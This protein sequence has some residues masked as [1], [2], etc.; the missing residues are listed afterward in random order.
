MTNAL[1]MVLVLGTILLALGVILGT[2]I[3][4]LVRL[5]IR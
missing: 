1:L 2:M 5:G 4:W 3:G